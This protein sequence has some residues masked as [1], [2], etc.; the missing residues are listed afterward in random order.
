V[1][2]NWIRLERPVVTQVVKKLPFCGTRRFITVFT[3][4]CHWSVYT[5]KCAFT[6]IFI[7]LFVAFLNVFLIPYDAIVMIVWLFN[8]AVPAAGAGV[9]LS[10]CRRGY[11]PDDRVSISKRSDDGIFL[12]STTSRPT[13]R[14]IQPQSN[15]YRGS[16]PGDKDARA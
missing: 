13:L 1:Y 6:Y 11:G 5:S 9:A 12:P 3:G 4:A 16:C 14:P 10:T 7:Y 2:I 8:F 15:G